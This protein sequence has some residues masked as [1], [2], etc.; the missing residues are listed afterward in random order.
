MGH[1]IRTPWYF[2]VKKFI[3]GEAFWRDIYNQPQKTPP[4]FIL[5][6]PFL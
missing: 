5:L 3:L 2:M 4:G 1:W 6:L